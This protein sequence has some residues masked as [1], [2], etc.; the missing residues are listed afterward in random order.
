VDFVVGKVV[1]SEMGAGWRISELTKHFPKIGIFKKS[2]LKK[3]TIFF[4]Q[5]CTVFTHLGHDH[6]WRGQIFEN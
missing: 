5:V 2:F 6:C 4:L 3:I 1:I